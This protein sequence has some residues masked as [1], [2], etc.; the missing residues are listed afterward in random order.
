MVQQQSSSPLHSF[1]SELLLSRPEISER[2]F[3]I[4]VDDNAKLTR[5]QK[6]SNPTRVVVNSRPPID[7]RRSTESRW[8]NASITVGNIIRPTKNVGTGCSVSNINAARWTTLNGDSPQCAGLTCPARRYDSLPEHPMRKLD[9]TSPEHMM[10]K[11]KTRLVL[12]P[13]KMHPIKETPPR[14]S[15]RRTTRAAGASNTAAPV[16]YKKFSIAKPSTGNGGRTMTV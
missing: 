13:L 1:M 12:P 6:Y 2:E 7:L 11:K 4:I 14:T 3:L 8:D 5:V 10:K 9:L 16:V 15:I